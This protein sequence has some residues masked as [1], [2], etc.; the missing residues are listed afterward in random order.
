M[1][2][3]RAVLFMLLAFLAAKTRGQS[4]D[5]KIVS[6]RHQLTLRQADT[7]R[8]R[9]WLQLASDYLNHP[10]DHAPRYVDTTLL[11]ARRAEALSRR[12]RLRH[13]LANSLVLKSQALVDARARQAQQIEEARVSLTEAMQLYRMTADWLRWADAMFLY[14]DSY[15]TPDTTRLAY[16]RAALTVYRQRG[17]PTRAATVLSEIAL[18]NSLRGKP[19]QALRIYM[20]VLR[21]QDSIQDKTVSKTLRSLSLAYGNLGDYPNALRYA[22]RLYQTAKQSADSH[23]L[24]TAYASLANIHEKLGNYEQ[25]LQYSRAQLPIDQQQHMLQ[26]IVQIRLRMSR[27]LRLVGRNQEAL[28]QTKAAWQLNQTQVQRFEQAIL[29]EFANCY[30]ALHDYP[31][32]EQYLLKIIRGYQESPGQVVPQGQVVVYRQLGTLYVQMQRFSEAMTYLRQA[33]TIAKGL[34]HLEE[35]RDAVF[36]LY[37]IDSIRGQYRTALTHYQQYVGLNN[38]LFNETRNKQLASLQIQFDTEKKEQEINLLQQ[39]SRLQQLSVRQALTTRNVSIVGAG[40][41]LL[42]LGVSYNRYRLKQRS[43]RQLEA[44]Q[45]I[46]NQKNHSLQQVLAEKDHLLAE[47][48]WM[49]KEIH[50]RVKNNLQIIASLLRSQGLYL[51]DE[52]ALAAIRESQNRVQAMALL[53]QKLYQADRLASIPMADYSKAIVEYLIESFDR[54]DTIDK[55]IGISAIEL[56]VT[57]AVPI[58]LIINEAVTNALKYAFL[59]TQKGMITVRLEAHED[60]Q[61]QLIVSDNGIR[62]PADF[63]PLRSRTLGLSLIRGLSKQIGGRLQITGQAGVTLALVFTHSSDGRSQS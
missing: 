59:P 23:N 25:A 32:A 9:L 3:I 24:A 53:H 22:Q 62:F 17:Q 2:T 63:D 4:F 47:K 58:G 42:L 13:W 5:A 18:T 52:T 21:I 50:H 36:Q 51:K 55:Q 43:N 16:F 27:L 34:D 14:G 37:R 19:Q 45:V 10:T 57:L 26:S 33:L 46:I 30:T 1:K 60:R 49:L 28:G 12:L 40:L 31:K 44:K 54:D 56:D 7:V 48:E 35:Q 39:Q 15:P 61:Y 11:Y 6:V 20:D 29:V 41:L 38:L 8:I